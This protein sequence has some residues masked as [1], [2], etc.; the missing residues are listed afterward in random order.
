MRHLP[1]WLAPM[2]VVG[3]LLAAAPGAATIFSYVDADGVV[4]FTNVPGD[5]RYRP[6][7][8]SNVFA[9]PRRLPPQRL[10]A[11]RLLAPAA[12][13]PS[14]FDP[15]ILQASRYLSV[16]PLLVKA[17][18]KT[19]SDF[20]PRAI[21]DRGAMGLMQL[22]PGTARD[23]AVRNPFDPWENIVGGTRYLR[24]Q[25]DR[26]GL[27]LRLALAAYNAGP[28]LVAQLGRVPAI[29]ETETYIQRVLAAYRQYQQG[30][31]RLSF[32]APGR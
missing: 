20:N 31:G 4:H 29:D 3:W 8:G 16:D 23:L 5:P 26:F 19:E 15:L 2:L 24:E 28:N 9:P 14:H 12:T 1:G 18:I 6:V 13:D 25:L 27:D 17:V 32:R 10:P 30:A 21:S 11:E 7:P 22:M